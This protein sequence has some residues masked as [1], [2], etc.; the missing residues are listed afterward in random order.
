MR[1]RAGER[2]ERLEAGAQLVAD[3]R[4]EGGR[5]RVGAVEHDLVPLHEVDAR[6]WQGADPVEPGVDLQVPDAWEARHMFGVIREI[7]AVPGI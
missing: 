6:A 4:V 2:G 5:Q 1:D 3:W 7:V